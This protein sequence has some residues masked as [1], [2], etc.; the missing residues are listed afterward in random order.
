MH[1]PDI[2]L[3]SPL[4]G[5]AGPGAPILALTVLWHPDAG[6]V[7]AQYLEPDARGVIEL[8]RFL[9]LFAHPG[10]DG[11]GLGHGGVS[12]LP[13]RIAREADGRLSLAPPESRMAVEVNGAEIDRPVVLDAAQLAQGVVLGLGRAILLCIHWTDRL[14]R[15]NK[16]PGLLGVS[17]GAIKV[18][19]L[20]R[21]VA[22]T[23]MPVL[24]LG[25][26][27][28]GKEVAARAIHALGR[29]AAAQ[30]VAVNMAVLN[31]GLA[32]AELFGA[33]R[34]A[35]TGAQ[36]ARTGLFAEADGATL[37]LD[38]IGNT[39]ASVQ[40][41]LLRVLESGEYRP[42]G[43][44][45]DRHSSARVIAAT[46]QDLSGEDFNQALLRRLER[47]VIALPA[48]RARRED[49]GVLMLHSLEQAREDGAQP[50]PLPFA[51]A[52]A[53]ANYDWPGN[54]RQLA[55]V[56]GRALL[57]MRT[58][59]EPVFE[60]LV[61]VRRGTPATPA[62]AMPGKR[63]ALGEVDEEEILAA[64]HNNGWRIQGAA[65]ELGISRP[66]MYKLIEAHPA[67]RR[68]EDIVLDELAENLQKSGGDVERCAALL[69]T[70]LEALR[71]H[72]RGLGLL[73]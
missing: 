47:F 59:H 5:A 42:L 10:E 70:P 37:F 6:R 40:P 16:V 73:S 21:A 31:E 22:A 24:L 44:D 2:T 65:G 8:S 52:S 9:P 61:N 54:V 68:P 18:R 49:I 17:S 48:L 27:G 32:A 26:T 53:C 33:A 1:D 71:R 39:P 45:T 69:L 14:P 25:E 20:I 34:G 43:G 23:D 3:T 55:H 41:M 4:P 66:S 62:S 38:E 13:L 7:G 46:D 28:T 30:L 57:E 60:T 19:E 15:D 64:L 56:L 36:S 58:G 67:I 35:Y 63:R 29:R 51:F 12:R 50:A 11:L 72:L